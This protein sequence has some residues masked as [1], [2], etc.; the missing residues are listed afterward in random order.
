AVEVDENNLDTFISDDNSPKLRSISDR[1]LKRRTVY[2]ASYSLRPQLFFNDR[3]ILCEFKNINFSGACL[4]I[5]SELPPLKSKENQLRLNIKQ[6]EKVFSHDIGFRIAWEDRN[7]GHIIGIEFTKSDLPYSRKSDRYLTDPNFQP[8]FIFKDPLEPSRNIYGNLIDISLDGFSFLT[9]MSNKHLFVGMKSRGTLNTIEKAFNI[10]VRIQ[11]LSLEGE[12]VRIGFAVKNTDEYKSAFKK[13]LATFCFEFPLD[14]TKMS[15]NIGDAISFFRVEDEEEYKRV[16]QLRYDSYASKDKLNDNAK[17]S[18]APGLENEGIIIGGY[19]NGEL[20]CSVELKVKS[21]NHTFLVE[22]YYDLKEFGYEWESLMEINRLCIHPLAQRSDVLLTLFKKIHLFSLNNNCK[23]VLLSSTEELR[24]IYLRLGAKDTG[25]SYAHPTLQNKELHLLTLDTLAYLEAKT[26]NPLLWKIVYGDT[27]VFAN[28]LG[29]VQEVKFG[30]WDKV[31]LKASEYL[32][33]RKTKKKTEGPDKLKEESILA[34]TKSDFSTQVIYPYLKAAILLSDDLFVD[35][36]I[37]QFGLSRSYFE[38]PNNWVSLEFFDNFLDAL[39]RKLDLNDLAILA[40]EMAMRKELV[41]PGYY[42]LKWFGSI[43]FFI[44]QIKK[45]TSK[46][47]TNRYVSVES[48][49]SNSIIVSFHLKE[50]HYLPKHRSSDLNFQTLLH[51]GICLVQNLKRSDV[52]VD[53]ISSAYDTNGASRFKVI[54]KQ[55]S[56]LLKY[57]GILSF[58]GLNAGLYYQYPAFR[59]EI[60][61]TNSFLLLFKNILNHFSFKKAFREIDSFYSDVEENS[62]KQYDVLFKTKQTLEKHHNRL[63]LLNGISSEIHYSKSI[64]SIIETTSKLICEQFNFS[65]CMIM[66]KDS[67]NY[68]RTHSVYSLEEV[69]YLNLLWGFEIDLSTRKTDKKVVSTA[70]HSRQTVL[71]HDVNDTIQ[72]LTDFSKELIEKLNAKSY[73]ICPIGTEDETHGVVIADK[74]RDTVHEIT[75]LE[76]QTLEEISTTL[77]VAISKQMRFDD[78]NETL[79]VLK[80]YNPKVFENNK[81]DKEKVSLA[82]SR[83]TVVSG[84]LDVR[85]FTNISDIYPPEVIIEL[86]NNLALLCE[87]A[88]DPECGHIDKFIG[89]EFFFTWENQE[90]E[91]LINSAYKTVLKINNALDS[92]NEEA[93]KKNFPAIKVGIGLDVGQVIRG[94]IGTEMRM[95]YTSIGSSVN[96]AARLQSLNKEFQSTLIVSHGFFDS[97]NENDRARFKKET[98]SIRGFDKDEDVFILKEM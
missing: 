96:K 30:L 6:G 87:E 94:N 42:V 59:I 77:A 46:L 73:V 79:T 54:W 65:R 47:N 10:D 32:Y 92:F 55:N 61:A 9:S 52:V 37:D 62:K 5:K 90:P 80:R 40:G 49:S 84:F 56:N 45:T 18:L 15:K 23:N 29:L 69:T 35:K 44:N 26:L 93:K 97:L 19:I 81:I 28:S 86:I 24:T 14:N 67:D 58:L 7:F 88:L 70:Y 20:M 75:P 89:D 11:N 68:L 38:N 78:L 1:K 36:V 64:S 21:K 17:V 41:G 16:V 33:K 48:I 50:G 71:I 4:V 76:V 85:G 83:K 13:Y 57:F 74:G 3:L 60:L 12:K 63:E 95:D 98:V 72:D 22:K 66:L 82:G 25:K 53:Q 91:V 51:H 27:H 43:S 2:S 39:G 8:T 34:Y 31:V